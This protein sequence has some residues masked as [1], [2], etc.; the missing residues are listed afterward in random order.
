MIDLLSN[1]YKIDFIIELLNG[2]DLEIKNEYRVILVIVKKFANYFDIIS[3]AK[4]YTKMQQ[5][6]MILY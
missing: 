5:E 1:K 3:F 2:K 4:K 6:N